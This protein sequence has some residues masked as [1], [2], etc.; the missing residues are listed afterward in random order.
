MEEETTK[1]QVGKLVE[2]I[3]QIQTWIMELEL[4]EV[5][6]TPQEVC[7]QSEEIT[8][9]LVGRIRALTSECKKLSDRSA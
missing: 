4:Q 6:S 8:K 1:S 3:Q 7:N 9:R 5:S 2:A